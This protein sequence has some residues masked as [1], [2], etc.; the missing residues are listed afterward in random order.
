MYDFD[1]ILFQETTNNDIDHRLIEIL[2]DL[3]ITLPNAVMK[4]LYT[5]QTTGKNIDEIYNYMTNIIEEYKSYYLFPN[6][7]IAFYPIVKE[8]IAYKEYL[9]HLSDAPIKLG[10]NFY[11]YH[12]FIKNLSTKKAYTTR[13]D[14]C[15]SLGYQDLFPRTIQQYEEW[16][17]QIKDSYYQQN[18]DIDFYRLSVNCGDDALALMELKENTPGSKI[19]RLKR[20]LKILKKELQEMLELQNF[21]VTIN[22][23]TINRIKLKIKRREEKLFSLITI[24]ND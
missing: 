6:N 10:E 19:R 4:Q 13:N 8:R 20:E 11:T 14:I 24:N 17:S 2:N 15:A 12:P 5:L 9:C 16:Y 3:Q 21:S 22:Q 1:D 23:S 18:S 7:Y